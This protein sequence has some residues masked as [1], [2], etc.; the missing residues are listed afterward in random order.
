MLDRNKCQFGVSFGVDRELI[1]KSKADPV[2]YQK[3]KWATELGL[4]ISDAKGWEA[5]PVGDISQWR[6]EVYVFT[7]QELKLY[8]ERIVAFQ[9]RKVWDDD[10]YAPTSSAERIWS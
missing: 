6:L 10:L 3:Q 7:P 5:E 2:K 8:I 1:K 4:M 9:G